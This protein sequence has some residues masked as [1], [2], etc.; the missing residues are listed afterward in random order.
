MGSNRIV[1]P[2]EAK[3]APATPPQQVEGK[4]DHAKLAVLMGMFAMSAAFVL[5]GLALVA[6]QPLRPYWM[7]LLVLPV[8]IGMGVSSVFGIWWLF[9]VAF[10]VWKVEDLER[11][12]RWYIQEQELSKEDEPVEDNSKAYKIYA[13]GYQIL[14]QHYLYKKACTRPE[15]EKLGITQEQWNAVNT[16]LVQLRIKTDRS[17]AEVPYEKALAAW[18]KIDVDKSS[19]L[20]PDGVGSW[21]RVQV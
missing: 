7:Y 15:C 2:I 3:E 21:K 17:W 9:I 12:R 13:A 8:A 6:I 10:R 1:I 20:V 4:L 18:E 19:F 14:A 16:V 5:L 11:E